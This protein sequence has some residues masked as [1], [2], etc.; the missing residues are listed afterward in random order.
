METQV[1][2]Q[3]EDPEREHCILSKDSASMNPQGEPANVKA[4]TGARGTRM[5]SPG[6]AWAISAEQGSRPDVARPASPGRLTR[7]SGR[8]YFWPQHKW[9]RF[10]HSKNIPAGLQGPSVRIPLHPTPDT[11][12]PGQ[13]YFWRAAAGRMK[14]CGVGDDRGIPSLANIFILWASSTQLMKEGLKHPNEGLGGQEGMTASAG[15]DSP[16][17]E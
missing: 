7:R 3:S 17:R 6:S 15:N 10:R 1:H 16:S 11:G 2:N 12:R 14:P 5:V 4:W 13:L 8:V 9:T